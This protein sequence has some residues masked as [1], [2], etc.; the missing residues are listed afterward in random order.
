MISLIIT[1][2][3][4][5]IALTC[6]VKLSHTRLFFVSLCHC[7]ICHL[8]ISSPLSLCFFC[9]FFHLF[10]CSFLAKRGVREDIATFEA[11]NITPEIRQSVE[12]LLNRNKASFDP[13]VS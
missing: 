10:V 2:L 5:F 1:S 4:C 13:K 8:L 12:E 9:L 11:R 3:L 7:F 6:N